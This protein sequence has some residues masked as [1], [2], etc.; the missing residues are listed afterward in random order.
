VPQPRLAAESWRRDPRAGGFVLA[1]GALATFALLAFLMVAWPAFADL[2]HRLTAAVWSA[3]SP[4]LNGLAVAVTELGSGRLVIPATLA[5]LLWMAIRRNWAGAIYVVMTVLGGYLLGSQIVKPLLGRTRPHGTN[6]IPLPSDASMPSTHSL[7]AFLFFATLCVVVM[8]DLP[9]GRH[10]KRWLAIFSAIVILAVGYSRVYLG[11]HWIGDVLAA[12]LLG[13]AWWAL[14]TATYFGSVT[15]ERRVALRSTGP[16][17][18]P[19][20][21]NA[22]R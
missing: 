22:P 2:D 16:W 19:A 4:A 6:L 21:Q 15:E 14:T 5:L 12:Y 9:T 11:V 17:T 1:F 8:L 20:Q 3:R 13:G 7:A 18:P 10:V